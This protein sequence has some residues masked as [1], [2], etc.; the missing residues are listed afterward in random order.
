MLN[1]EL[2]LKAS[3]NHNPVYRVIQLS[4][5]VTTDSEHILVASLRYANFKSSLFISVEIDCFQGL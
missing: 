5:Y 2:F 1:N 4:N 3:K